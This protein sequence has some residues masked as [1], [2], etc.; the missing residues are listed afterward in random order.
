MA[1]S[2]NNADLTGCATPWRG[3]PVRF[4]RFVW[5][6]LLTLC[7]APILIVILTQD[8]GAHAYD[9][10]VEHIYRGVAFSDVLSD[11]VLH[12]RWSQ[13]LHWG[14]GS[15]LFTFQ[16]PLPYYAL[17]LLYRLG[18]PHSLGW[19]WLM[20]AGYAL[21]F[22]GAY[23]LVRELGGR[24]WPAL[25]AAVAYTY[26]PYVIRNGLERGSN[27][28][29]SMFLYP[30]VLWSL[31]ALAKRPSVGRF[32]LAVMVWAACIG[33]HVLGPLMLAPFAALLAL[34][35]WWR[36]G[37]PAPL[38]ALVAG[39]LLTAFIWAPMLTEQHWVHVERDFSQPEAIPAD[40]PIPLADLLAPPAVY[41]MGLDNNK[42]G[43]AVGLP[44][45]VFL[46]LGAVAVLFAPR[47]D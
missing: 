35:L 29:Y 1:S 38:L 5:L 18:L 28:A 6:W 26:A 27:E 40:N 43:D 22:A 31:I 25:L 30:L 16:P 10:A 46:L 19:R 47:R 17:D 37:S 44:Q 11:G 15:P 42:T 3:K 34:C 32:L 45:T 36:K 33:S 24:R 7:V 41:D 13:A 8:I 23:L 39:G 4:P 2:A 14:L 9:A 20:A 21:A 12:P